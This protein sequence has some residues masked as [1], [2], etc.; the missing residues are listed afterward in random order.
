MRPLR[1]NLS[2]LC[3]SYEILL[4]SVFLLQQISI[5]SNLILRANVES[6]NFS[7]T[8]LTVYRNVWLQV[9]F[10]QH[11]VLGGY[12]WVRLIASDGTV[13]HNSLMVSYVQDGSLIIERRALGSVLLDDGW[14]QFPQYMLAFIFLCNE[15]QE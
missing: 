3:F 7:C 13:R 10:C 12:A 4:N 11:F 6:E 2:A 8:V 9:Q 14:A 5:G 1:F 15:V